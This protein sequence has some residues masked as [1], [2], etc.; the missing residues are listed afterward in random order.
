MTKQEITQ[1][2]IKVEKELGLSRRTMA[3]LTGVTYNTYRNCIN[4]TCTATSFS[5]HH[6]ENLRNSLPKRVREVLD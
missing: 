1:K 6:L 5:I 3:S 2:I 4:D